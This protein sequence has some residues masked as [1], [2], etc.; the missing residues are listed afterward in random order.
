MFLPG[1]SSLDGTVYWLRL[2]QVAT[3]VL[4][5]ITGTLVFTYNK[6]RDTLSAIVAGGKEAA[7]ANQVAALKAQV[8]EARNQ[9]AADHSVRNRV[10]SLLAAVDGRI[11]NLIDTGTA[12][13]I[14]RMPVGDL[15]R[16]QIL[17]DE[18]DGQQLAAIA[19]IGAIGTPTI[20]NGS[21]GTTAAVEQAPIHLIVH[22]ALK[23]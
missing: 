23:N 8:D 9:L 11:I 22:A 1:W 10:R 14:I 17:L 21:L 19:E 5:V 15:R 16:L 3:I 4:P 18:P 12:Q 6:H 7:H 13:M 20:N 2:F